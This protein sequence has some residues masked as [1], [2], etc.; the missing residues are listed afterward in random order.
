MFAIKHHK[1][2]R[3]I[4]KKVKT[5]FSDIESLRTF[6]LTREAGAT[7]R[8]EPGTRAYADLEKIDGNLRCFRKKLYVIRHRTHI[9]VTHLGDGPS[10]T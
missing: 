4:R 8:I 5:V 3:T 2:R 1:R 6:A 10:L 9:E 7:E